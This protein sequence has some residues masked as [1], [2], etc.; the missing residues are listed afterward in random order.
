MVSSF[1]L[2]SH[3]CASKYIFYSWKSM[4]ETE[5]KSEG[6][7]SFDFLCACSTERE[8][9]NRMNVMYMTSYISPSILCQVYVLLSFG[10]RKRGW[11]LSCE[12]ETQETK[13]GESGQKFLRIR[14]WKGNMM[15]PDISLWFSR[16]PN[17]CL[18][19]SRGTRRYY[20]CPNLTTVGHDNEVVILIFCPKTSTAENTSYLQ[21]KTD[22]S[23]ASFTLLFWMLTPY[24]L[25]GVCCS[26]LFLFIVCP[27]FY[28]QDT[29]PKPQKIKKKKE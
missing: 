23:S 9:Q 25:P 15:L 21:V 8:T 6:L 26:F 18:L 14:F 13:T 24:F 2:C 22:T 16:K 3:L 17:L 10:N 29:L 20:V 27:C 28:S 5:R 7:F 11:K 1:H 12:R 4:R 19:V